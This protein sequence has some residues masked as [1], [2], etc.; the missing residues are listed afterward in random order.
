[1]VLYNV[2]ETLTRID[3]DGSVT[4][5]LAERWERSPALRTITFQLLR[6]VKFRNGEPFDAQ[7]VKF[8]F[9]RNLRGLWKDAPIF[10]NDI[11]ALSW[12]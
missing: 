7:S 3:S 8:S 12:A 9:A 4:P 5:L 6:G 1:V 10:A 11:A 2:F